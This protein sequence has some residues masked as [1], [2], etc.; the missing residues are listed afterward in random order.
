LSDQAVVMGQ[1]RP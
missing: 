1:C